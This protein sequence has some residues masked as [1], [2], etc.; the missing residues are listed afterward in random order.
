MFASV[1]L[2]GVQA[3]GDRGRF[4]QVA[5]AQV[6]GDEV[7]KIF[8]QVLPSRGG[9]VWSFFPHNNFPEA[10][11]TGSFVALAESNHSGRPGMLTG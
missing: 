1:S 11:E 4:Y 6:T 7:V 9:H 2:T 8:H 10:S 3:L 5:P